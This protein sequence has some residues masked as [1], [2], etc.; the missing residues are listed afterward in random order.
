MESQ[1][2]ETHGLPELPLESS[3]KIL[4]FGVHALPS[5]STSTLSLSPTETESP[6]VVNIREKVELLSLDFFSPNPKS[7]VKLCC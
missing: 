6:I 3:T 5:T 2:P 7:S 1:R 4:D